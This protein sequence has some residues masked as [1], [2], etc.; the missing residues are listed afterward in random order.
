[1]TRSLPLGFS[2]ATRATS[3]QSSNAPVQRGIDAI[4][5]DPRLPPALLRNPRGGRFVYPVRLRDDPSRRDRRGKRSALADYVTSIVINFGIRGRHRI[6]PTDDE[7]YDAV[8]DLCEDLDDPTPGGASRCKHTSG[9]TRWL[10]GL[11]PDYIEQRR[12][13]RGGPTSEILTRDGPP[14]LQLAADHRLAEEHG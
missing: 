11:F 6:S 1:M 7:I 4:L 10:S 3:S 9:T 5:D 13:R 14:R 8:V 12:W 2:H